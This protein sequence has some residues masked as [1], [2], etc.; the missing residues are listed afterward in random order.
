MTLAIAIEGAREILEQFVRQRDTPQKLA[1]RARIILKSLEGLSPGRVAQRLKVTRNTVKKWVKRWNKAAPELV[2]MTEADAEEPELRER[3][4]GILDDAPRSGAPRKFTLEQITQLIALA[5]EKP[6]DSDRPI[7]HWTAEELAD[8][9]QKRELFE[10]ISRGSVKRFL[11][12]ADLK[13]HRIRYWLNALPEDREAFTLK[14]Q[15][16][17][18]LYLQAQALEAEGIH[19]TSID[20]MTGIQALERAHPTLPMRAGQE[21]RQEFEYRRHGTQTLIG[22][23]RVATGEV[24]GSIGATRTEEDFTAHI[25]RT[26][27]TDPQAGWIFV[28]DQLNIHKS[29]GLVRLVA[30]RLGFEGDLGKKGKSG[31][32]KSMATRSAFLSDP[33]HR[34]RVLYLPKHTSWLNQI[35]LWFSILARKLLKRT[36]FD[37]TENLRNKLRAFIGYFNETMAKPFKW[38]Y[39]GKALQV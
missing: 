7:S 19:V 32:L 16:V 28:V 25:T 26:L 10:S 6:A 4:R 8:E 12:A 38:T 27:E 18:N 1:E 24:L 14:V 20:E 31:I 2:V 36:S 34:I 13:P 22:N 11:E 33:R 29:E 17:C 37:S 35:E 21:E 30:Q 3:I 5:C 39:A 9:A 15:E 23:L